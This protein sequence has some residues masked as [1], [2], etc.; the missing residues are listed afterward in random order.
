M[1]SEYIEGWGFIRG[2]LLH[3]ASGLYAQWQAMVVQAG[4]E[5]DQVTP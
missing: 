3:F 1:A 5:I 2:E 4:Y